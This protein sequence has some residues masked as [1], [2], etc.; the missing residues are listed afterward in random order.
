MEPNEKA[1][2]EAE[3]QRMEHEKKMNKLMSKIIL[4]EE[5][6]RREEEKRKRKELE[7]SA[8]KKSPIEEKNNLK[9]EAKNKQIV[10]MKKENEEVKE[11]APRR[12]K[13][14]QMS[15]QKV[16]VF[17]IVGVLI[18][19]IVFFVATRDALKTFFLFSGAALAF[20]FY[21][22]MKKKLERY[23]QIKKMELAFPDFISL[24][25]SNL[26]AGMTI[27]RALVLSARKEFA[28]LDKEI[29]QVGKD[30]LTGREIN[31]ALSD[32][33]ERINSEE[34]KK[35][36]QLIISGL[37]SGG[38]I[39]VLLEQTANYMR[40]RIFVKKRA[41]SNVLM[42]V[43]FIFFAVAVGA[44]LLYA[45]STVLVQI[46]T[47]MFAG[48]SAENVNIN[49]PFTITEVNISTTFIIYF[50]V[51][52]MISTAVLSSLILG[53]VS[54]GQEKEGYKYTL[55]LVAIGLV[56][57]FVARLFLLRYF[58]NFFGS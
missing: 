20:S 7:L 13:A 3:K 14:T 30:I 52:F 38:N 58:T 22:L 36:L 55:I 42:Y 45:L 53:L 26:R 32:M 1:M 27:D 48:V 35:T 56:V 34:I 11:N 28:P 25:S 31:E 47:E 40:E 4:K 39:A 33:G 15:T 21:L 10:P 44:P 49:L 51:L 24:V 18:L 9:P 29:L 19:A 46:M 2:R 54:K 57:F 43:I 41:A 12:K 16:F 50:A 5:K 23:N 6:A 8:E 37:R 17:F